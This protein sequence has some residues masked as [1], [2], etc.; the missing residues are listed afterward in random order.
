MS[1]PIFFLSGLR[2]RDRFSGSD[3]VCYA[4]TKGRGCHNWKLLGRTEML[5]NNNDPEWATTFLVDFYFEEKQVSG[6]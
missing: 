4:F 2:E 3:P 6:N 5:K 1:N